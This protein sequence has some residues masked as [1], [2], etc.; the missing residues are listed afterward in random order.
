MGRILLHG[1]ARTTPAIRTE[2]KELYNTKKLKVKE[3]SGIFNISRPTVY[4]WIKRKDNKDLKMGTKTPNTVLTKLEE[5]IICATRRSTLLSLD[6]L[7]IVLKDKIPKLSRSNLHRCLQRNGIS[8]LE[9]IEEYKKININN[10]Q[11]LEEH[12]KEELKNKIK[13]NPYGNKF[14]DYDICTYRYNNYIII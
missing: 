2:I 4:K 1:S 3:I 5:Q 8:N 9:D 14:K 6:D 12:Y 13:N 10:K 11:T 7:Y